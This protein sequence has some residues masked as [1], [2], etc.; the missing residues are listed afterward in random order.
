MTVLLTR[1]LEDNFIIAKKLETYGIPTFI[2]PMF[3]VKYLKNWDIDESNFNS[4]G[5]VIFTSK[6]AI[7]AIKN[8]IH[9]FINLKCFVV[10]ESTAKLAKDFKFKNIYIANNSAE[11]LL[12]VILNNYIIEEGKLIYFCGELITLDFEKLLIQHHYNIKKEI[13]YKI[14]EK[15]EL[16]LNLRTKI[17][18]NQIKIVLFFSQN[19][20]EIF[21]RLI[22]QQ[23]MLSYLDNI[24][25]FIISEKLLPLI[26]QYKWQSI[27]MFDVIKLNDLIEK[28][29]SC[30]GAK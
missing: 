21:L 12:D 18:A 28:I 13:V 17:I 29:R 22:K 26:Q 20:A 19:T 25:V 16:S 5:A 4:C 1:S 15:E 10:G 9:K 8:I 14:E 27:F 3:E 30:Y 23:D 7:Y 6:N 24:T 2:E 11:S